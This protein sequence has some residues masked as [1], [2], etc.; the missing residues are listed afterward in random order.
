MLISA[1]SSRKTKSAMLSR[2]AILGCCIYLH[3]GIAQPSLATSAAVEISKR[4]SGKPLPT[5]DFST[6]FSTQDWGALTAAQQTSLKPLASSWKT[7]SDIQKRK[8]ISLTAR[9]SQM[10]VDEQTKLHARMAQWAALSPRQ[11]EQARLNF[12]EAKISYPE[13]K[14]SKWQAYQA[15]SAEE[16]QKLAKS[17]QTKPPRTAL[18]P[19][20]AASDQLG[21]VLPQKRIL[22][23]GAPLPL[24]AS[25]NEKTLLVHRPTAPNPPKSIL[26]LAV[27]DAVKQ[28]PLR[29]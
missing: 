3:N 15:L 18:A 27:D 20:P 5:L 28:E 14:N 16:K 21:L 6:Q 8:W 24:V 22:P 9:Y 4:P 23:L 10:S 1:S 19:R 25:S 12:A 13:N 2:L 26:P 29:Q 11:R 7:L 17:A